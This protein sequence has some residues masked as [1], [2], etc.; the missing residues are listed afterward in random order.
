MTAQSGL[1]PVATVARVL[2][3]SER[4]VQQLAREGTIP[5]AKH[6]QYDLIACVQCYIRHLRAVA[7]GHTS[8]DG[9]LDLTAERARLAREQADAQALKNAQQRG[10]LIPRERFQPAFGTIL[11]VFQSR[12]RSVP[13]RVAQVLPHLRREEIVRLQELH[14]EALTELADALDA[15]TPDELGEGDDAAGAPSPAGD[16]EPVG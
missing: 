13:S 9:D 10:E 4:R 7:A 1:H 15:L 14:D 3:L 12:M 6:G 8:K 16:S 11:S 2:D 5:R